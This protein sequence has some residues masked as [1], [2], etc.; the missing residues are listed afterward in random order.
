MNKVSEI[1]VEKRPSGDVTYV[2]SQMP[3]TVYFTDRRK[4]EIVIETPVHTM[5]LDYNDNA[6]NNDGTVKSGTPRKT[7][8][9]WP[10]LGAVSIQD[11]IA[12][13][14]ALDAAIDEAIDLREANAAEVEEA[15][16]QRA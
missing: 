6:Y 11:A 2:K 1:K 8:I 14:S 10:A 12:F 7:K 13:R 3:D 15:I 4:F 5:S 9:N 16:K